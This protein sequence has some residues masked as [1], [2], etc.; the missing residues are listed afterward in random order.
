MNDSKLPPKESVKQWLREQIVEGWLHRQLNT[1]SED[2]LDTFADS[3]IEEIGSV[4]PSKKKSVRVFF[5]DGSYRD[6]KGDYFYIGYR[7][8]R[9]L[10]QAFL[11]ADVEAQDH[12]LVICQRGSDFDDI[13]VIAQDEWRS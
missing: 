9:P 12:H 7:R 10:N 4:E 5:R 13:T 6:Y 1:I 11:Y 2:Q 3:L 8:G